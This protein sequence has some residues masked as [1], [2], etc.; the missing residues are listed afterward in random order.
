MHKPPAPPTNL[1]SEPNQKESDVK[2]KTFK[3]VLKITLVIICLTIFLSTAISFIQ[4]GGNFYR[5]NVLGFKC[6]KICSESM[7]PT[8]MTDD[9]VVYKTTSLKDTKVGDIIAFEKNFDGHKFLIVHRVYEVLEDGLR[10]KG[11]NCDI[12]D[13]WVVS[14]GELVGKIIIY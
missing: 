3:N 9:F 10:T 1:L 12:P 14:D 11:D 8:I 2:M 6:V 7:E 13:E 4:S 5:T